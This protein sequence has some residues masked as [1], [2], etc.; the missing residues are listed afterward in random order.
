[1]AVGV[2][3]VCQG[4]CRIF[5]SPSF[6]ICVIRNTAC[7]RNIYLTAET[8]SYE[9]MKG[10]PKRGPQKSSY[11]RESERSLRCWFLVER[12]LQ[13]S[14]IKSAVTSEGCTP[15]HGLYGQSIWIV[16]PKPLT[17]T[18]TIIS[19]PSWSIHHLKRNLELSSAQ[20]LIWMT[21]NHVIEAQR[22]ASSSK[23]KL[24]PKSQTT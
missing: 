15:N 12:P 10:Q 14:N 4:V 23:Q 16:S 3:L 2:A 6:S 21:R 19:V 1:M 5:F 18:C 11:K 22:Q 13:F 24:N 17:I 7:I 9:T 20:D 8:D